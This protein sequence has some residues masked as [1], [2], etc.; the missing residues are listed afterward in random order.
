MIVKTTAVVLR[1][2]RYGDTSKIVTLWTRD[3]G[4]VSVLAKGARSGSRRFGTSLEPGAHI[5]VV[6]YQKGSRELQTLSQADLEE[7]YRRIPESLGATAAM[8]QMLEV[9]YVQ[10]HPG[11]AH[12]E[13]YDLLVEGLRT[14]DRREEGLAD[15]LIAYRLK[16]ASALGFTPSFEHC[17]R[18]GRPV[19]PDRTDR[20]RYHVRKGGPLCEPCEQEMISFPGRMSARDDW[21]ET[22]LSGPA[23]HRLRRLLADPLAAA[24]DD[25]APVKVRNEME[26]VVRLYE[27]YHLD[28][29]S[30][31]RTSDLVRE[32]IRSS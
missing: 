27:R 13:V 14:I 15:V 22:V 29:R 23:Y 20:I 8:L 3:H 2:L 26:S 30:P 9:V 11:G 19:T 6:F 24:S 5:I 12:P 4:R 7:R 21:S 1:A 16:I 32:V 31:L 10:T 18:C 17:I 25:P 28:Q